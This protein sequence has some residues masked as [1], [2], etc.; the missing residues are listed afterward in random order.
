MA[1][2]T[3]A[4]RD[5]LP[6]RDFALPKSRQYPIPDEEHARYALDDMKH[7][8]ARTRNR[9]VKA[10]KKRYPDTID[11]QN[12]PTTTNPHTDRRILADPEG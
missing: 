6:S 8:P 11:I 9:I 1:R 7:E 3:T 2:L 5:R 10:I 4:Q 12:T